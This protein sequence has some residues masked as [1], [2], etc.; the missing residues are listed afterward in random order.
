MQ[1]PGCSLQPSLKVNT[2][3]LFPVTITVY[4]IFLKGIIFLII[5]LCISFLKFYPKHEEILIYIP[6]N[7]PQGN[8]NLMV[9]FPYKMETVQLV[10]KFYL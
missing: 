4:L 7:P 2:M 3:R 1:P 8:L 5:F 6:T 9:A 10:L